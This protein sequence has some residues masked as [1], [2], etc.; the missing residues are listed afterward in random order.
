MINTHPHEN[1]EIMERYG[2]DTK[3]PQKNVLVYLM[4]FVEQFVKQSCAFVHP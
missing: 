4:H 2:D 3:I 1:I